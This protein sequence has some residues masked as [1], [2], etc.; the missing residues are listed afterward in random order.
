MTDKLCACWVEIGLLCLYMCQMRNTANTRLST[1]III[2]KQDEH[3]TQYT[4]YVIK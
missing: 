3:N 2:I 1:I 4:M